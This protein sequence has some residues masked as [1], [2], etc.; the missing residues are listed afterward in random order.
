MAKLTDNLPVGST[1]LT[2]N[3]VPYSPPQSFVTGD[4][5]LNIDATGDILPSSGTGFVPGTRGWFN[6]LRLQVQLVDGSI[7]YFKCQWCWR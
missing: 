7:T 2:V 4:G 1:L 6:R 3:N 5:F